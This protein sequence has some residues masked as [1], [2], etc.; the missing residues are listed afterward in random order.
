M[1][2]QFLLSIAPIVSLM[3]LAALVGVYLLWKERREE[4]EHPTTDKRN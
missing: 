4:R 3:V 1:S 2:E